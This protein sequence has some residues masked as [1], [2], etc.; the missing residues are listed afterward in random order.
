M[1]KNVEECRRMSKN[2]EKCREM[3][4][5]D[6]GGDL[7]GCKSNIISIFHND[8]LKNQGMLFFH[9]ILPGTMLY[10]YM[11]LSYDMMKDIEYMAS[12]EL[13]I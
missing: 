5:L 12:D 7:N 1:S 11:K 10:H 9:L 8:S 6:L 4:L 3:S 13:I 2:V